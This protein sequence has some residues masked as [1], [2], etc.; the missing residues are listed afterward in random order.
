MA[1]T[2]TITP[3]I[4]C[5]SA[6]DVNGDGFDDLIIGAYNADGPGNTR[7]LAGDS[8]V[9]FGSG[10]IGGSVNHVTHL[11][12]AGDDVLIGNG[13]PNDMV[14]GLGNDVLIGNGS[15]DVHAS[16]ARAMTPSSSP[17]SAFSA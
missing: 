4:R 6:G 15:A 17:I 8:Y 7:N 3:A 14:G 9:L 12:T 1:R 2:Q 11:G 16:A 5:P 13:A 10:T